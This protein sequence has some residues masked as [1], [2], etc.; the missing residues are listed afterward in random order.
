MLG[1][2]MYNHLNLLALTHQAGNVHFSQPDAQTLLEGLQTQLTV[3]LLEL[4]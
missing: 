3:A 1:R 2:D 4:G